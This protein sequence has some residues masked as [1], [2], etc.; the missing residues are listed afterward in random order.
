MK[1]Y[2]LMALV[3]VGSL[4]GTPSWGLDSKVD[5]VVEDWGREF[6]PAVDCVEYQQRW[7]GVMEGVP[8]FNEWTW[9]RVGFRVT[10]QSSPQPGITPIIAGYGVT[11]GDLT[12]RG[13]FGELRAFAMAVEDPRKMYGGYYGRLAGTGPDGDFFEGTLRFAETSEGALRGELDVVV[14]GGPQGEAREVYYQPIALDGK[15]MS[16]QTIEYLNAEPVD[17][18]HEMMLHG[19]ALGT[20]TGPVDVTMDAVRLRSGPYPMLDLAWSFM[21]RADGWAVG[22]AD[23]PPDPAAIPGQIGQGGIWMGI[24]RTL[25]V[26]PPKDEY[27]GMFLSYPRNDRTRLPAFTIEGAYSFLSGHF[28]G[29]TEHL[30]CIPG[31]LNGDRKVGSIDLD[32]VRAHWNQRTLAGEYLKGDCSRDGRVGSQ[33]LDMVRANWGGPYVT[34]VPE[35]GALALLGAFVTAW[36][37]IRKRSV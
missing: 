12:I 34:P 11:Y 32:T 30:Y 25:M 6:A 4:L 17:L 2:G 28:L 31:D 23:P 20:M 33:D 19:H 16:G 1:W 35:P 14:I 5:L 24:Q 10:D 26:D 9:D 3:L 18:Y 37:A 7:T 22:E 21:R 27:E 29:R 8:V 36:F 15:R 13:E